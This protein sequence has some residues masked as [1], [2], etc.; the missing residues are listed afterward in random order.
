M[1]P[2]GLLSIFRAD[3]YEHRFLDGRKDPGDSFPGTS[4]MSV[5]L[6]GNARYRVD[7]DALQRDST[8]Q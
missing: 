4:G 2:D 8:Q 5:D 1:T 6:G 7:A 3:A